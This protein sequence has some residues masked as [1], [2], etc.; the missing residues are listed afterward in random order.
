MRSVAKLLRES[1]PMRAYRTRDAAF[2]NAQDAIQK[3]TLM[4]GLRLTDLTG[5]IDVLACAGRVG[6]PLLSEAMFEAGTAL[7]VELGQPAPAPTVGSAPE[8]TD[9]EWRELVAAG[10]EQ[11]LP[12]SS[13]LL[14]T[15]CDGRVAKLTREVRSV[16]A[17]FGRFTNELLGTEALDVIRAWVPYVAERVDRMDLT[18]GD[19]DEGEAAGVLESA[20]RFWRKV[21]G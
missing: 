18:L 2:E 13:W 6:V 7:L 1:C 5:R 14:R 11:H 20:R 19:V 15:M 3:L 17:G 10:V 4:F 12:T 9:V 16:L 8:R 21:L